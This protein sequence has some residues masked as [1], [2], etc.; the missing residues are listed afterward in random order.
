MPLQRFVKVSVITT[1][2]FPHLCKFVQC[3]TPQA[4]RALSLQLM[5]SLVRLTND[6]RHYLRFRKISTFSF[7]VAILLLNTQQQSI[8]SSNCMVTTHDLVRVV[9]LLHRGQ[10]GL[11]QSVISIKIPHE[12]IFGMRQHKVHT[13]MTVKAPFCL[14][15]STRVHLSGLAPPLVLHKYPLSSAFS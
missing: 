13:C 6:V 9:F 10:N 8:R 15:Q 14:A 7:A 2:V 3:A 4:P 5:G 12:V 1:P 11:S